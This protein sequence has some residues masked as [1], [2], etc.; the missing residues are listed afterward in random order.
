MQETIT[1]GLPSCGGTLSWVY[2]CVLIDRYGSMLPP[3]HVIGQRVR[4][5]I[6]TRLGHD[7]TTIGHSH[8][9]GTVMKRWPIDTL[10]TEKTNDSLNMQRPRRYVFLETVTTVREKERKKKERK[11]KRE[12]TLDLSLSRH[13]RYN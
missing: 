10:P 12:M 8:Y 2:I 11:R 9:H 4:H 7:L 6:T 13:K 3:P 5:L 1:T